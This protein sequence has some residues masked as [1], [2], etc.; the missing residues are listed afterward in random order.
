MTAE[1]SWDGRPALRI[2]GKRGY[3]VVA[4]WGGSGQ[5]TIPS[6]LDAE[7]SRIGETQ[8]P[9]PPPVA[10]SIGILV[11]IAM[12]GPALWKVAVHVN[13]VVH[14]AAHAMVGL[15]TGRR[16]RSVKINPNGGGDTTIAGR[17]GPG[18]AVFYFVGYIGPS[19]AG[20]VAAWLISIGR[21]VAVLWLGGLLL[22]AMVLMVRNFFGGIVMVCCGALLYLIVRYTSVGV[23][24]AVA[25]GVTWFLLMS[26]VKKMLQASSKPKDVVD[27]KALRGMTFLWPSAWCFLWLLGTIAALVVGGAILV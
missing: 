5:V 19:A 3:P 21:I 18:L 16:V 11:F 17:R 8:T 20:L 27:A 7:L 26:G 15:G 2:A 23:E 4:Q 10:L 25:Y 9:L 14:E 13:T 22:A 24:I 12:L 1:L 6:W